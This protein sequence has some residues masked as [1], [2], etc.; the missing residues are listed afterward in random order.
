MPCDNDETPMIQVNLEFVSTNDL[1]NELHKRYDSSAFIA[2]RDAAEDDLMENF[3]MRGQE[4]IIQGLTL[5]LIHRCEV[6]IRERTSPS[7]Y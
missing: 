3:S 4:R 2:Q 7:D 6:N 1:L 5:S